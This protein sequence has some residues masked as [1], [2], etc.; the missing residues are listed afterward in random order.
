M[1]QTE[2]LPLTVTGEFFDLY[3]DRLAEGACAYEDDAGKHE[4][5]LKWLD[6]E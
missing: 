1:K 5:S 4:I 6:M 2:E 3:T